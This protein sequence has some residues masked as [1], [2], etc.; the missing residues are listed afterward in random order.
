METLTAN[1]AQ[2]QFDDVLFKV[3]RN[4]IA[5]SCNGSAIAV[6]ISMADYSVLEALRLQQLQQKINRAEADV[7]SGRVH[8]GDEFLQSLIAD[9]TK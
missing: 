6:M 1:E 2:T 7:A 3:Q 4:P 8:D 5:I 9:T